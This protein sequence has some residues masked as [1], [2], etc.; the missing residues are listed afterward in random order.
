MEL[1]HSL[2]ELDERLIELYGGALSSKNGSS[3]EKN[4]SVAQGRNLQ[5]WRIP[6]SCKGLRCLRSRRVPGCQCSDSMSRIGGSLL[7]PVS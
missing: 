2:I 1:A 4:D 3:S 6:W 7:W 5:E